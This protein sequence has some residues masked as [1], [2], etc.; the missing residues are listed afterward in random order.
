MALYTL[1]ETI[2]TRPLKTFS[3]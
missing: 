1:G 2:L 3:E